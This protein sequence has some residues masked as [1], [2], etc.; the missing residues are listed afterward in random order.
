MFL[1]KLLYVLWNCSNRICWYMLL[2]TFLTIVLFPGLYV[3]GHVSAGKLSEMPRDFLQGQ[4]HHWISLVEELGVKAFVE[5][6]LSNS[7]REGTEHLLRISGQF[8]LYNTYLLFSWYSRYSI[9][10]YTYTYTSLYTVFKITYLYLNN[11]SPK[12]SSCVFRPRWYEAEHS[13]N[14]FLWWLPCRRFFFQYGSFQ[15][16]W[17][18]SQL[19]LSYTYCRIL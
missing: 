19:Q 3:L 18:V 14:G 16:S 8:V 4:Y 2:L 6:T 9:F 13:C 12:T 5:L 10:T 11:C 17:G 15:E 7:I 1:F